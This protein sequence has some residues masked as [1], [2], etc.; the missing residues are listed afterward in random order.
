MTSPVLPSYV[1]FLYEG[2]QQSRESALMRTEMETGIPR[3]AKI[4][5]RVLTTRSGRLYM[6]TKANY[7][8]FLT[9][10]R[11]EINE[12]ALFF[13]MT[14]PV[15]EETIEARFVNGGFTSMPMSASLDFWEISVQIESWG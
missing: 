9:W 11:D 2:C 10:Y 8:A 14:D 4:K 3:Q 15:T 6:P 12:G 5:S 1:K 13:Y 7:L